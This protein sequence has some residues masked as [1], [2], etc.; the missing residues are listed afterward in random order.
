[1]GQAK[2]YAGKLAIRF[3]YATNGRGIYGV[4]METGEEGEVAAY[5]TPEA[6]WELAFPQENVRRDRLAA[7]PFEDKGGSH[8][9]GI[10]RTSRWSG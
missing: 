8:P 3:T 4:D 10:I 5:P 6:L 2:N 7:V 1:M 9:G